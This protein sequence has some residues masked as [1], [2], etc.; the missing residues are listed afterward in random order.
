MVPLVFPVPDFR[1]AQQSEFESGPPH[2][3]Q[4]CL[5]ALDGQA[6][7]QEGRHHQQPRERG[8][9]LDRQETGR[10]LGERAVNKPIGTIF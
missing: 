5:R 9:Q 6:G 3:R 4:E 7:L 10:G 1:V 2:P 8:L